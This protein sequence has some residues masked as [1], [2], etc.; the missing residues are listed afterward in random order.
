MMISTGIFSI[1]VFLYTLRLLCV[2]QVAIGALE[3]SGEALSVLRDDSLDDSAREKKLRQYTF[4]LFGTFFSILIRSI[5]TLLISLLPILFADLVGWVDIEDVF[6]YFSRLDVIA[7]TTFFI[8][9]SYIALILLRPFKKSGFQLNYSVLDQLLHRVAFSTPAIQFA[10]ADIEKSAF[11]SSYDMVKA[12]KPIFITSLPRSGTTLLL[13]VLHRFPSLATHI[14]RDMPFVMAP[15]LWSHLSS[16]FRKP[17]ETR[18]RAHGDGMQYSY[19]SPEAFEEILWRTFWPEKY[20]DN[21][22]AIWDTDDTKIEAQTFFLE[23]MKKIIA[24]RQPDRARYGRYISK[25]NGNIARIDLIGRMFPDAKIL[26]PVRHPLEH[27]ASLLRQHLNFIEMHKDEKF[28]RRYMDDIGHYEFGELHRPIA[29]P[30]VGELLSHLNPLQIDYW[31]AYWIAAFEYVLVRQ[32]KVSI[33]S[34]ESLCCDG[35]NGL[36]EICKQFEIKEEGMVDTLSSI[37]KTPSLSKGGKLQFDHKLLSRAEELHETLI[38][39]SILSG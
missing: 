15:I 12:E 21:R 22:I 24:L 39:K 3:I 2:V 4:K 11:A 38:A 13:E 37:F 17:V 26:V 8:I 29:F 20:T 10:A 32:E 16:A 1:G 9:L 6:R 18:E 25:N 36:A 30:G 14:Y 23:H 7:I 31:V 5:L 19:D 28:I 27:A 35:R 33:I 34:Y